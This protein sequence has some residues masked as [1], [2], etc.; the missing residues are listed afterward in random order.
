MAAEK[1]PNEKLA[2]TIFEKL[3]AEGLI[4]ERGKVIFLQ[5]LAGGRLNES[6]WKVELEQA[7]RS[8]TTKNQQP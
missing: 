6:A 7:L 3:L 2:E 4:D 1:N 8:K 5:K